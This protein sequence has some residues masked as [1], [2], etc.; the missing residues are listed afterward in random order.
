MDRLTLSLGVVGLLA[1][2][3]DDYAMKSADSDYAY[4]EGGQ[5]A[6]QDPSMG[7]GNDARSGDEADHDD[8]FGS[9]Q[10]R[11]LVSLMPATTN[12]Y[13]FVANPDRNTVTRIDVESLQVLTAEVGVEPTLVETASDYSR[14]VTFD[15]GSDT[16]SVIDADSMDVMPVD[17]RA[18]LNQMKMSPD[19]KWVIC[20]HDINH[21]D[22]SIHLVVL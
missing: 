13:V 11:S 1:G 9:E 15:K 2:C 10:E 22:S 20:Y 8:G 16:V 18:N 4:E 3:S 6:P 12:V 5:A 19:G 17:I 21:A 7:G 14:A